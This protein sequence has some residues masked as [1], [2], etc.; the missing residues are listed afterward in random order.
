MT[1]IIPAYDFDGYPDG[2]K[3]QSFVKGVEASV[4]EHY[5]RLLVEKKAATRARKTPDKE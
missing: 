1:R 5:A 2:L 4:P 3:K